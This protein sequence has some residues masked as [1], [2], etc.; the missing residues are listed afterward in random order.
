MPKK[1]RKVSKAKRLPVRGGLRVKAYEILCDAVGSGVEWGWIY[2]HKHV[3]DPSEWQIREAMERE[4][5]NAIMEKFDID[6][7]A[8]AE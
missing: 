1:S 4:V 8:G 3:S 2:A 6:E 7:P 5:M